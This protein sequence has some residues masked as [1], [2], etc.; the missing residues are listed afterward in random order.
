[1]IPI[2]KS[3]ISNQVFE[4][5]QESIIKGEWLPGAK[6]PSENELTKIFEVSRISVRAAIQRLI[7][8]G[9]LESRR[10]DGTYVKELSAGIFMNS[11][12]PLLM[13]DKI[14]TLQVLE[15]RKI[16]EIGTV[17]L[18]AERATTE[19]IERLE[20]IYNEMNNVKDDPELFPKNDLEFHLILAEITR[21]PVIIK[22]NNVIKDFLTAS[23]DEVTKKL[24]PQYGLYYH[25][26]IIDAIKA[27]DS[28]LAK[29]VMEE[30]LLT[31]IERI[32]SEYNS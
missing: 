4:Q 20:N 9:L 6:I 30:H 3:N 25:K 15:Y 1:M 16:M 13:L 17:E 28:K 19:D 26:K 32:T 27:K 29:E 8:L 21:N 14:S 5:L 24:G 7:S 23:M 18:A 31:T 11:L 22:A 2:K 10:G 12:I